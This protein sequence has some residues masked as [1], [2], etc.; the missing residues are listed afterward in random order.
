[1]KKAMVVI[2]LIMATAVFADDLRTVIIGTWEIQGNLPAKSVVFEETTCTFYMRSG[3][4]NECSYHFE[5][6]FLFLSTNGYR[7]TL[8]GNTLV[9]IP[10]FGE[11]GSV[12]TLI[13]KKR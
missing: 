2:F 13:K 3:D 8:T 12:V 7:Y 9:L 4:V 6:E 11:G 10:A 5:E 1:M